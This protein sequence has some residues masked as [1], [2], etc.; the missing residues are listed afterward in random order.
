MNNNDFER[1]NTEDNENTQSEAVYDNQND[2]DIKEGEKE[3][4]QVAREKEQADEVQEENIEKEDKD[5]GQKEDSSSQDSGRDGINEEEASEYVPNFTIVDDSTATI[6]NSES[7]AD[8]YIP[9]KKQKQKKS[10][11]LGVLVAACAVTLVLSLL[12]GTLAG[13]VAGGVFPFEISGGAD[14]VVNIIRSDREITV[15]E[16]PG[17]TGYENLTVAEVAALVGESVVEITTAHVKTGIGYEQYVTSGAGSGVIFYQSGQTGY[18]VTNYHVIEGADEITVR[19]KNGSSY[20]DYKATYVA[21]DNAEDIAVITVTVDSDHKLKKAVFGDSD[22]L[23][24]G[25]Q[26][27]AIGNPLGQLGG[28]VTDG[29]IS[30]LDRE[31]IVEDNTMVLL[32]TNAA[33]NPG[34]S[35]GGLFNTA[36]ELVGIVNAKQSSAGIEGLGF[37]IPSNVVL[38][39]IN[40]ILELGYIAGRITLG[41]VV[42]YG[43][44]SKQVGVFVTDAKSTDFEYGDRIIKINDAQV[45]TLSDYNKLVKALSP[46]Q[47][48]TVKVVRNRGFVDVIVTARENT[49]AY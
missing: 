13:A 7:D 33:I 43:E 28:T 36:G 22:K 25:E 45:S 26:V 15:N 4:G 39:D 34:N 3:S 19:I 41:I 2:K 29:I 31:I 18:I 40:D 30:A 27:V 32:Q 9:K 23:I 14:D 11:S 48:V 35:G 24:V 20:K 47:S 17:N 1:K 6:Y 49:S 8:E 12:L 38:K 44:Y 21:G 42:K 5:Y 46:G 10:V 16:V 37:A